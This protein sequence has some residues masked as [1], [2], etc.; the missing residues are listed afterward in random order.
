MSGVN[1]VYGR[2]PGRP[3]HPDFWRLVE[4]VQQF[5]IR[6]DAERNQR[7][8]AELFDHTV[9]EQV[10]LE[11]ITYMAMQRAL[12]IATDPRDQAMLA[13]M[14]VEAFLVGATF[15]ERGGHHA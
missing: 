9:N 11:S 3:S 13:A 10:D 4:V 8:R 15:K 5:D 7:R 14:Y 6:M 12:R 1:D 2:V